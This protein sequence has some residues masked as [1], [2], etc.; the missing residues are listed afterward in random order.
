MSLQPAV[1]AARGLPQD[2][3]K[4][5]FALSAA[6]DMRRAT[7]DPQRAPLVDLLLEA[8]DDGTTSSPLAFV[9]GNRVPFHI[10]HGTNDFPELMVDN[11]RMIE[12]LQKEGCP[13]E[14]YLLEGHSHFDT[15]LSCGDPNGVW[16]QT[17]RRW[18][19]SKASHAL[20]A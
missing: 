16:V 6:F 20:P 11:R 3:I 8:D 9:N 19:A 1:L 15:S 5:C 7:V 13:V 2:V 18:L 12:A 17:V 4:G 10:V 14:H